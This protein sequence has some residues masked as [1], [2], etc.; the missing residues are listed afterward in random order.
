MSVICAH[1]TP[2]DVKRLPCRAESLEEAALDDPKGVYTVARTYHRDQ[3]VLFDAHL[4]RLEEFRPK[5][6]DAN[7]TRPPTAAAGS[8]R[9]G[10]SCRVS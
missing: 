8:A 4:D 6:R 7:Q 5:G 3:T 1:I 2:D 9:A 10:A